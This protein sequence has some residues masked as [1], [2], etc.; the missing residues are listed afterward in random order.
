MNKAQQGEGQLPHI[1]TFAM[2]ATV[3]NFT[4]TAKALGLSQAAVSQRIQALEKALGASHPD[5]GPG[6]VSPA[7]SLGHRLCQPNPAVHR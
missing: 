4:A 2:A 7:D 1:A 5:V 6:N 3:G